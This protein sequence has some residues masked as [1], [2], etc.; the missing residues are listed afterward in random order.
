[1]IK[2]ELKS[3]K[4]RVRIVNKTLKFVEKEELFFRFS[5]N[6]KRESSLLRDLSE[7]GRFERK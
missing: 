2:E 5:G 4:V 1:L 3:G 6:L 7:K